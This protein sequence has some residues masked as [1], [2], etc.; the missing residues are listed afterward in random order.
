MTLKSLILSGCLMGAAMLAHG[1]YASVIYNYE[2]N[3]FGENEPLPSEKPILFTGTIPTMIDVVEISVYNHK[4]IEKREPLAT[5]VWKRTFQDSGNAFNA[6]LNY[7]LPASR[8]FDFSIAFFRGIGEEERS[9]LYHQLTANLNAYLEQNTQTARSGFKLLRKSQQLVADLNEIVRTGLKNYRCLTAF[10]FEGFSDL[11]RNSIDNLDRISLPPTM[12]NA[13]PEEKTETL[14]KLR[15]E[16]LDKTETLIA[17]EIK[18]LLNHNWAVLY[19]K[20][21]IDDYPTEDRPT[22]FAINAGYGGIWLD[23]QLDDR[24]SFGDAAYFGLGFPLSTSNLAPRVFQD[25]SIT[26][27]FFVKNFYSDKGD[28]Y[29]GPIFNRPLY[30]GIDYKLFSFI[31]LNGGLAIIEKTPFDS[32]KSVIV[33]KP[34][35]GLSA[36]VNI[37]L[38]L[39]K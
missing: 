23:G 7:P 13:T 1:Q 28:K 12:K 10:E 31:R 39:D 22:H 15:R 17:S 19:D 29:S 36:K 5:A 4:G 21:Y 33:A 11:V 26:V 14:K 38:S 25:A 24:S 34:F 2:M 8:K 37:S 20:R 3:R 35:L 27:G 30:A 16:Q 6:P 32:S 9:E 18:S